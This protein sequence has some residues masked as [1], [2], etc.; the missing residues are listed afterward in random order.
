[1]NQ[2]TVKISKETAEKNGYYLFGG[3]GDVWSDTAH[4]SHGG[5]ATTLCG[6]PMLSTNWVRI[7]E[8]N[9]V[10]CDECSRL[11]DLAISL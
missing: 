10:G 11:F 6:R 9:E 2:K 5:M 3:K 1:M 7:N 4:L 8:V